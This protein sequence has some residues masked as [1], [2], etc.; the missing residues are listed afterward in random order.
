MLISLP[1]VTTYE[2]LY[3]DISEYRTLNY[4][5]GYYAVL[6]IEYELEMDLVFTSRRY[7]TFFTVLEQTGGLAEIMFALGA[8]V[9]LMLK[10]SD[11]EDSLVKKLF[12]GHTKNSDPSR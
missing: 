7:F 10:D 12:K 1:G 4:H 9:A 8:A 6:T 5:M 11:H 3:F 2:Q